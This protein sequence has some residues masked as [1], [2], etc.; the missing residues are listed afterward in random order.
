MESFKN[1]NASSYETLE[2]IVEHSDSG[3]KGGNDNVFIRKFIS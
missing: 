2:W 1:V 3:F